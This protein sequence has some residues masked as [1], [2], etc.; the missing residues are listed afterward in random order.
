MQYLINHFI[1]VQHR[2]KK[3]LELFG[4]AGLKTVKKEMQQFNNWKVII[5]L[6]PKKM[7][8][9]QKNCALSY[10]MLV[11]QKK[12][13][14]IKLRG[15][16]DERKERLWNTKELLAPTVSIKAL[17]LT[18][19]SCYVATADIPGAFL[20]TQADSN[21]EIIIRLDWQLARTLLKINRELYKP[22]IEY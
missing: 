12:D 16:G 14:S 1:L 21:N 6:D 3:G 4:E 5:P 13:G 8:Q 11:K 20:Q 2:M 7:T 22:A 19:K 15:V 10:L 9:L 17:F 18:C